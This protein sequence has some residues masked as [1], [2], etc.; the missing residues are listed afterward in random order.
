MATAPYFL[1]KLQFGVESTAGTA[2]PATFKLVGE[3]TYKPIIERTFEEYPRGV[4]AMVTDGGFATMK[5]SELE[6]SGNLTFEE[7][8]LP[9][10]SG[11]VTVVAS[12]AGPYTYDFDPDLTAAQTI[13]TYTAEFVVD[14]GSTKHY[15]RE[16]A[17]MITKELEIEIKANELATMKMSMF[18]R[19]EQT[20]TMTGSLTPLTGRTAVPSNLF[21]VY[22]DTTGAGL[23]GTQKT[24]LVRV[25]SLKLDFGNE[26]DY[27]L[28]GR[29]DLD[30]TGNQP[31]TFTG[32]LD[33]T[34]E[35]NADAATEIAAWRA[36]TK[37]FIRLKADN[38]LAAGANKAITFDG[39]YV[40][41]DA[42]EFSEDSGVEI[43]TMKMQ[44]E[45]DATWAKAF[46]AI[47]INGLTAMI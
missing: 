6:F 34:M 28:D 32:T 36:G 33:L 31:Q 20:S 45:Y 44:L 21:K 3:G 8:L 2:V 18:G 27:T 24:G 17:H 30:M 19:A 37:R 15:Q 13:K 9:L 23:G 1:R 42:P 41:T 12:G 35:H 47:V 11:L 29:A 16:A 26:P 40:Y 4:R 10:N 25:A 38:G 43:V 5:G 46:N 22:V 7:I 14:D 39:C